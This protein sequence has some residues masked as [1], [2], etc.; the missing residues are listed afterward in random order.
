MRIDAHQHFWRYTTGEYGWIDDS[1]AALRRDFLPAE[2]RREMDSAAL[3]ACVA[4]QARQTLEETRW[5]L[6]LADANPFVAGVIGWVDLQ[7][8]DVEE[9]LAQFAGSHSRLVGVRH[10]VQ[11]E[12]DDQFML[13]PAFCRGISLLHGRDLTYDI[14]IYPKHLPVAAELVAR[15]PIQR[16]VLD[17]LAKP[18]IRGGERREWEKGFA[19]SRSVLM[20][21]ASCRDSLP[22]RT[23]RDGLPMRFGPISMSRSTA[24][25][26]VDCWP[27]LTGRYARWPRT[28]GERWRSSTTTWLE[29]QLR[30]ETP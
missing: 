1:M 4:V 29:D 23:G 13:R 6:Q 17:H 12:P 26:H 14:L 19:S 8:S 11:S 22:K 27:A 21:T 2:A 3:D 25:V 7:A 30:S 15:F 18:D 10:I 9:Q 28:T 20:C 5:L 16:F 24:S